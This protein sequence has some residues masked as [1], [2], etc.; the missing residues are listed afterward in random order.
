MSIRY[1]MTYIHSQTWQS[2]WYFFVVKFFF[3]FFFYHMEESALHRTE[4]LPEYAR[5]SWKITQSAFLIGNHPVFFHH[6][7]L[8]TCA[9]SKYVWHSPWSNIGVHI[10]YYATFTPIR[11]NS[12]LHITNSLHY[13][14]TSEPMVLASIWK[15]AY[16]NIYTTLF[17]KTLSTIPISPFPIFFTPFFFVHPFFDIVVLVK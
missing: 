13:C 7:Q 12:L 17:Y 2:R 16:T 6:P 4:H 1:M 10:L 15:Y 14:K 8:Q 5:V 9:P 3:A 11:R